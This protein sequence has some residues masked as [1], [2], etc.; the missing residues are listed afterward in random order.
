MSLIILLTS[1]HRNFPMPL[2]SASCRFSLLF[3]FQRTW[4]WLVK[5]TCSLKIGWSKKGYL[6]SSFAGAQSQNQAT[7]FSCFRKGSVTALSS[8]NCLVPISMHTHTHIASAVCTPTVEEEIEERHSRE[9]NRRRK[10]NKT[11]TVFCSH[12]I[13]DRCSR[14]TYI[15]HSVC[16]ETVCTFFSAFLCFHTISK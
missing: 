15:L 9:R 3:H 12:R 6:K 4:Q 11:Q 7:L 5:E 2:A 14:E 8:C 1:F 16:C 13:K 10:K